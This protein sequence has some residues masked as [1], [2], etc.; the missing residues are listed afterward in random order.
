VSKSRV[1]ALRLL[2][3]ARNLLD[4]M[5]RTTFYDLG[6]NQP[7]HPEDDLEDDI[8]IDGGSSPLTAGLVRELRSAIE[9]AENPDG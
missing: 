3:A 5:D 4:A 6:T 8:S 1:R 7:D 9:E 2:A